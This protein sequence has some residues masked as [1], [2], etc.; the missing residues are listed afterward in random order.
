MRFQDANDLLKPGYL[1]FESG[2]LELS[3]GKWVVAA[4]TRM[5]N[6]RAKMVDWWFSWLGD[7]AWYRLWHPTDHVSSA[8]EGRVDG[9]YVGASHIV[10]EYFGG[11]DGP[12]LKRRIQFHDPRETFDSGR[13]ASSGHLAVCARNG[14]LEGPFA[15][16]RMCHFVRDTD[17]G[18]EM[19]SRFWLGEISSRDNL[20]AIVP[21]DQARTL[22]GA[23]I[24][25]EFARRLHQHCV[26]EMGYLA[27]LLPA[28]YKRVTLDSSF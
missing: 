13:Y 25:R 12:L 7:I 6:A 5:P 4:L 18:C 14:P 24:D 3:D 11:R 27:E 23:H 15:T 9:R 22:R 1:P 2:H 20:G 21:E 10:E 8:W 19:R 26:E 16:G 28:L 17:Y